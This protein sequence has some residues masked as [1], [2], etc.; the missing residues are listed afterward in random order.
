METAHGQSL[1]RSDHAAPPTLGQHTDEILAWID[2]G[3]DG[4]QAAHE[5]MV[6]SR[7]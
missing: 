3:R 5:H 7:S 6:T 2:A 1:V 4:A